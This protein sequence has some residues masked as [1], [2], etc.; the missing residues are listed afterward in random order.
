M[1]R[2]ALPFVVF[3]AGAASADP[4]VDPVIPTREDFIMDFDDRGLVRHVPPGGSFRR[5]ML[6]PIQWI[7]DGYRQADKSLAEPDRLTFAELKDIVLD[8]YNALLMLDDRAQYPHW[9]AVRYNLARGL[10]ALGERTGSLYLMR[11]A[12]DGYLIQLSG[13]VVYQ[14]RASRTDALEK[15][16]ARADGVL[17]QLEGL[18][19]ATPDETFRRRARRLRGFVEIYCDASCRVTLSPFLKRLGEHAPIGDDQPLQVK[20]G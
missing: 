17:D 1:T 10:A 6:E 20:R 12:V 18:D 15:I 19:E 14:D 5:N 16:I 3:I 11:E 7:I 8:G 4:P 9:I 13:V 2:L